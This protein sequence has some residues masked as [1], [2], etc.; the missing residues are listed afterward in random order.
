MKIMLRIM[1]I[2]VVVSFGVVGQASAADCPK[3]DLGKSMGGMKKSLKAFVGA[4]KSGDAAAQAEQ[5]ANLQMYAK[6]AVDQTPMTVEDLSGG[7][8]DDKYA[9]YQDAMGSMLEQ[10][11]LL[12]AAVTA[13]DNDA[14]GGILKEIQDK[15]K[16]GHRGFKKRC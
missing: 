7:K 2:V 5:V 9:D 13:G 16:A 3:T 6:E 12:E 8:K 11:N 1:M 15:N 10:F 4:Y 14:I